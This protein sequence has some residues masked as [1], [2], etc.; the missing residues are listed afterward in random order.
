MPGGFAATL[1]AMYDGLPADAG[2]SGRLGGDEAERLGVLMAA[3]V[4]ELADR[5][6]VMSEF[7]ADRVRLD[8]RAED[9]GRIGVVPFG[10]PDPVADATPAPT[11]SRWW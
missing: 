3:E 7:A 5:F 10:M 4:V 11:G 9:A 8:A 2:A 6:V 1:A